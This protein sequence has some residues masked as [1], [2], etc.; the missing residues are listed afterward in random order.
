MSEMTIFYHAAPCRSWGRLTFAHHSY[1][2]FCTVS[3]MLQLT[4]IAGASQKLAAKG[5]HTYEK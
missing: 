1:N 5:R 3:R 2:S 4:V